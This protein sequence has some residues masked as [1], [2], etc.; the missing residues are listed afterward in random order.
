L[1]APFN[2]ISSL[3]SRKAFIMSYYPQTI[4]RWRGALSLWSL[5]LVLCMPAWILAQPA[6]AVAD[7]DKDLQIPLRDPQNQEELASLKRTLE[8][9]I[10]ALRSAGELRDALQLSGW[11]DQDQ[12]EDEGVARIHRALR[13]EI[14]K[15]FEQTIRNTLK[16]G[17]ATKRLA[18]VY[19]LGELSN[20]TRS[21]GGRSVGTSELVPDLISLLSDK[22]TQVKEAAARA[23]GK[24]HPDLTVTVPAWKNMFQI[25]KAS[26]RQAVAEGLRNL[27]QEVA[28]TAKNKPGA[29]IPTGLR[30][31]MGD[32]QSGQETL[33][34]SIVQQSPSVTPLAGLGLKDADPQVRRLCAET[35]QVAAELLDDLIAESEGSLPADQPLAGPE[36]PGIDDSRQAFLRALAE[37]LPLAQSLNE[38][39][40]PLTK[41]VSDTDVSVCLAVNEA[42]ENMASARRRILRRG[43]I[44]RPNPLNKPFEDP[45]RELPSAVPQL[46]ALLS[47]KEVRIRLASLYVLETLEADAAP[48]SDAVVK[49]LKDS[50]PFVCWAAVRALGKMNLQGNKEEQAV[51]G[52]AEL[53]SHENGD[54]RITTAVVLRRYAPPAKAAVPA[55]AKAVGHE[56]IQTRL[57]CISA[58]AAIGKDALGAMPALTKALSDENVEVRLAAAKA[59]AKVGP[60]DRSTSDGLKKA[61]SDPESSVRQAV[62]DAILMKSNG[63]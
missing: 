36:Q 59:L 6:D 19:L 7:L 15:R 62:C 26:E 35:V 61:L 11:R 9:R 52:L 31:P 28:L 21:I 55:L 23:L 40:D 54:V 32:P 34:K 25:G 12:G 37:M 60:H 46:A 17:D 24:V 38:L 47:H 13:S 41:T 1:E 33:I 27:L 48:A 14:Q 39:V 8:M 5:I 57:G 16:E 56:D 3:P 22:D 58:L 53:L 2:F 10:Q 30:P 45:L 43:G 20:S 44:G 29:R 50:D 4:L 18:A 49:A 63:N 42:L 51:L